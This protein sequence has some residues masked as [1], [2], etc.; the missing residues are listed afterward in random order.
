MYPAQDGM[1]ED[2]LP[3]GGSTSILLSEKVIFYHLKFLFS[4]ERMEAPTI[5]LLNEL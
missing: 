4:C 1:R 3:H 2:A 5:A